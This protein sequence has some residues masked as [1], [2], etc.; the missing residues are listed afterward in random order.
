MA[1]VNKNYFRVATKRSINFKQFEKIVQDAQRDVHR[2][3]AHRMAAGY[4]KIVASWSEGVRPHFVGIPRYMK[5]TNN[6]FAYVYIKG[7]KKQKMIFYNLDHGARR[8]QTVS[9]G[10]GTESTAEEKMMAQSKKGLQQVPAPPPGPKPKFVMTET[11]EQ[12][13]EYKKAIIPWNKHNKELRKWQQLASK[14][15]KKKQKQTAGPGRTKKGSRLGPTPYTPRTNKRGGYSGPGYSASANPAK[16]R[17]RS[18]SD[19]A[20]R[21]RGQPKKMKLKPIA[22]RRWSWRLRGLVN[23]KKIQNAEEIWGQNMSQKYVITL[24]YKNAEKTIKSLGK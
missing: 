5:A 22:A 18:G 20:W 3:W 12:S 2:K 24:G 17:N 10:P 15:Q 23:G 6:V 11:G 21:G 8:G 7:T 16:S 1:R 13:E 9:A 19:S 14:A 4:N